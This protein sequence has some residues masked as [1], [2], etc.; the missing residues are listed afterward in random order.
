MSFR[1]WITRAG[2]LLGCSAILFAW[3]GSAAELSVGREHGLP[4]QTGVS[5]PVTLAPGAGEKVGG[6]QFELTFDDRYL[7]VETVSA[8]PAATRASKDLY[9]STVAPGTVRVIVAGLNQ[10]AVDSGVIAHALLDVMADAPHGEQPV[11]LGEAVLS[12]P[13]G[14]GIPVKGFSGA[15]VIGGAAASRG[16]AA[17]EPARAPPAHARGRFE[18]KV[19][20]ALLMGAI[21]FLGLGLRFARAPRKP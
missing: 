18:G 9:F 14:R 21:V 15:V 20:L 13:A 3:T 7:H 11:S 12:D 1:R 2:A 19:A 6:V 16:T 10:N 5:M 17:T 4:G 8:G